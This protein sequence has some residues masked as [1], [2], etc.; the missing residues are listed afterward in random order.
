MVT[1]RAGRV[2]FGDDDRL[3]EFVTERTMEVEIE[4]VPRNRTVGEV[5]PFFGAG[6]PAPGRRPVRPTSRAARPAAKT[7]RPTCASSAPMRSIQSSQSLQK[8]HDH[9]LRP[10]GK[11]HRLDGRD[12]LR[13]TARLICARNRP[14]QTLPATAVRCRLNCNRSRTRALVLQKPQASEKL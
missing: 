6:R 3:V 2:T 4:V 8:P 10:P 7:Y 13:G 11:S 5:F 14:P 9:E 12:P 1:F